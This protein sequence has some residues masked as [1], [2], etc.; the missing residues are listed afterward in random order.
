MGSESYGADQISTRG[1][2]MRWSHRTHLNGWWEVKRKLL[3]AAPRDSCS[4][5]WLL[6]KCYSWREANTLRSSICPKSCPSLLSFTRLSLYLCWL[7]SVVVHSLG[8]IPNV[9]T[10]FSR[11]CLIL[12]FVF[13][14]LFS[15]VFR[16]FPSVPIIVHWWLSRLTWA[17][18]SHQ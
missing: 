15:F 16:T 14:A 11:W 1:H 8:N 7:C 4:C 13:S 18:H 12:D 10:V 6:R 2:R 5:S 9:W 17:T 3:P